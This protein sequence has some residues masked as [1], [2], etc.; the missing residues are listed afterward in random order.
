VTEGKDGLDYELDD[1]M[2]LTTIAQ[3]RAIADPLREAVLDLLLERAATI[4]ELATALG[5]PKGTV[6]YHVKLLTEAGITTVVRT[7][8][9]RAVTESYYGRTARLHFVGE[10]KALDEAGRPIGGNY[11]V[12]AARE[13]ERAHL[14]DELS[15]ILR[16]ARI[17]RVQLRE[18]RRRMLDLAD[19]FSRLPRGG[20]QSYGFVAALYPT[21]HPHLPDPQDEP[22]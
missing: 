6:A 22:G 19:E 9:V 7:R 12:T 20:E 15:A 4:T 21:E 11:L 8:R 3:V 10:L 14:D 1:R 2:E 13:S 5:R 18:F 17:P 16:Y